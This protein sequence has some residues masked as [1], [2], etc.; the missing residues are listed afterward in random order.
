MKTK[1]TEYN[2]ELRKFVDRCIAHPSKSV[3][4]LYETGGNEI[5]RDFTFPL[6][7]PLA[8]TIS[9]LYRAINASVG[10]SRELELLIHHMD[11]Q[12]FSKHEMYIIC[13]IAATSGSSIRTSSKCFAQLAKLIEAIAAQHGDVI[14]LV[15]ETAQLKENKSHPQMPQPDIALN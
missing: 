9:H 15:G 4:E 6:M 10:K 1:L 12:G 14:F 7:I 2:I 8:I 3:V 11:R 13:Q 5:L